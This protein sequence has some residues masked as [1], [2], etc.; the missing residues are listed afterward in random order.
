MLH[1]FPTWLRDWY[2]D[3]PMAR[4][5]SLMHEVSNFLSEM[6]IATTQQQTLVVGLLLSRGKEMEDKLSTIMQQ[7]PTQWP[8]PSD[9]VGRCT[10]TDLPLDV[11]EEIEFDFEDLRGGLHRYTNITRAMITNIFRAT[12]IHLLQALDSAMT[13]LAVKNSSVSDKGMRGISLKSTMAQI[14]E[15]ICNDVPLGIGDYPTQQHSLDEESHEHRGD[16]YHIHGRAIRAW[17]MLFPLES[18]MGVMSIPNDLRERLVG[19]HEHARGIV[20][21]DL[22]AIPDIQEA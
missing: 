14:A 3:T 7:L 8:R 11:P 9:I 10:G 5:Q 2:P 18:A 4:L 16:Q 19:L 15:S 6:R 21:I 17:T 1:E 20:G 22:D 12:R 13:Y